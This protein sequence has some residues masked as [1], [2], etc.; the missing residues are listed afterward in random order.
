MRFLV[1]SSVARQA[2]WWLIDDEGLVLAWSGVTFASL[3]LADHAAH[4]FRLEPDGREFR[5]QERA[6]SSWRWTAW[7]A[8]GERVAVS[9]DWFATRAEAG[10]AARR[11]AGLAG[12]A[13]GP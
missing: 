4:R 5:I 13:I 8:S 2:A 1:E 6:G 7:D 10:D 3:A 12:A 11:M 9:G